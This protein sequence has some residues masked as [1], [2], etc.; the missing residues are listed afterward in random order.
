VAFFEEYLGGAA[1]PWL[2]VC[3]RRQLRR[4]GPQGAWP[5]ARS[6]RFNV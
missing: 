3:R 4:R 6:A 2:G 1:K 5:R